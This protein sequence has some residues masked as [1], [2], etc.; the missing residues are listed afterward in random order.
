MAKVDAT[1]DYY[2]QLGIQS[3]ATDKEITR[4]FRQLAL[5]FHPDRHPGREEE[6]VPHFQKIQQ[7][8]EVLIDS[9]QRAKYDAE[10][11]K[12]VPPIP[13]YTPRQRP[14]PAQPRNASYTT[15]PNGGTYYARPPPPRPQ[16][17][18]S[19]PPPQR[20]PHSYANGAD[21]FTHANFRAPPTAQRPDSRQK[22]PG[23][24]ANVF[25]A[26]QKMKQ[27]RAEEPREYNPNN[28][29][30]APF[31]RSKSTRTPSDK[32]GFNPGTP[33]GDEGQAKSAYR[34]N[35]DRPPS[36]PVTNEKAHAEAEDVPF[37]EGNR[38]RTPYSSTKS[39]ERTSMYGDGLGRS[40]SVRDSPKQP[41]RASGFTDAGI[42]SD[43]GRRQQR[44]SYGGFAK[45]AQ[46]PHMYD[47]SDDE[48]EGDALRAE[49]ERTRRGP[50]QSQSQQSTGA[51]GAF[52]TPQQRPGPS[53]G[54]P[55]NVFKSRS[56]EN[57]N[58]K[59]SPS[60]W[61]GKFE[62]QPDYFA[63]NIQKG[64]TTKG[65]TSPTRGRQHQRSATEKG[66]FG[67]GQSQPPP[68]NPFSRPQSSQMPPPPP[69][70]PPNAQEHHSTKFAPE[71]WAET[72][73]EPS[74][75][76]PSNMK[77]PSPRRGSAS[78]RRA[79]PPRKPSTAPENSA[80]TGKQA[81]KPKAKYQAFAEDA[82][83][84]D[85]MDID[86]D[87][88]AAT[89][90]S[91][92][93]TS[94]TGTAENGNATSSPAASAPK[95]PTSG[96]DLNGIKNVEPFAQPNTGL[97]GLGGLGDQLPFA[98]QA[99][100]AHPTKPNTVQKLK[101]PTVPLAPAPP[102]SFDPATTDTY[103]KHVEGYI[104]HFKQYRIAITAH[105]T[106]R[107]AEVE[108]LD[109]NFVRQRGERTQKLGFN[110]YLQKMREDEAVL[111]AWKIAQESHIKALEQ[112][113]D[114]RR[115]VSKQQRFSSA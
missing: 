45:K 29:N 46:F 112:C 79:N 72:F 36:S 106:A 42:N 71:E 65:R 63:P 64:S 91:T 20:Q 78:T 4:A 34:S 9:S 111:E 10:R 55:Y 82:T 15:T 104:R 1:K 85:A 90:N 76:M 83:N 54:S 101:F 35:Y 60:D 41:Q 56:E 58:M 114:V 110:S 26:W 75:A 30:G 68:V 39:G 17:H 40:A 51:Q 16:P 2:E 96:L 61:H 93:K 25:T 100:S 77:E 23:A 70:P 59:F 69:G 31:G 48:D 18:P 92:P 98:S 99:S 89:D 113:D 32:K 43:S 74:W 88:P 102:S 14:P 108:E 57:I 7:A 81:S 6:F 94:K 24:K 21:R 5:K 105:F 86:T 3:N 84:G 67:N 109:D 49:Y 38:F 27:P 103:F 11:R 19:R 87:S 33:G 115:K 44:N 80:G 52:S 12:R 22:E 47:S 13:P 73:K 95:A 53:D 66:P 50:S 97:N 107:N 37:A 8:H 28:P 62:G